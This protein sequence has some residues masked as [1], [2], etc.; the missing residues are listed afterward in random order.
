ML[1][2]ISVNSSLTLGLI[3]RSVLIFEKTTTPASLMSLYV[4]QDLHLQSH[5]GYI[6]H[7]IFVRV[8]LLVVYIPKS[9]LLDYGCL[10]EIFYNHI[11][12]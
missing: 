6:I 11:Y 3:F 8:E 9:Q 12:H 7:V 1:K 5:F 4:L 2:T 10:F